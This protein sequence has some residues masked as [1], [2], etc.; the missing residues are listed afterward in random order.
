MV[1]A[2][3]LVEVA[4]GGEGIPGGEAPG[5]VVELEAVLYLLA[6]EVEEGAGVGQCQVLVEEEVVVVANLGLQRR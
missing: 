4:A 2:P 1:S 3:S 6:M 5:V